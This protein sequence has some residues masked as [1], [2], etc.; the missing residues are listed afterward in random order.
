MKKPSR[1]TASERRFFYKSWVVPFSIDINCIRQ[2][3]TK[4]S[5]S[6]QVF[7]FYRKRRTMKSIKPAVLFVLAVSLTGI[8][9]SVYAYDYGVPDNPKYFVLKGGRY[10]PGEQYDINNFTG[11]A[12]SRLDMT[13]GTNWEIALGQYSN[14]ELALELGIGYFESKGSPAAEPG[15]ATL[16]AVPIV[17]TAKDDFWATENLQPYLE[18]GVGAYITE[19]EVR[20]NI[21]AF[22]SQSKTAYGYHAGF[23]LKIDIADSMF[24]DLEGR[25]LFVKADYGGQP[26][27]LNG[28]MR[29]INLGFNY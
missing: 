28:F 6:Q 12:T 4:R 24:I 13:T 7:R 15:N 21:G 8:A 27:T 19:L 11:S 18:L 9:P 23:G 26:V 20:G 5:P 17:V 3:T 1:A 22:S 25:Y 10:S 2:Y 29:T 14:P 16:K